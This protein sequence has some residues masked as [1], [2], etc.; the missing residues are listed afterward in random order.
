[1]VLGLAHVCFV[2]SDLNRAVEF[3]GDHLGFQVAFEF[4]RD[5]GERYGVYMKA[6]KRT[7]IEMFQ[8]VLGPRA[9]KQ[10]YGHI[11][12]EVDDVAK[13]V[14]ELRAKGLELTDAKLGMDQ[15]W[16]AW[17]A[18][19]DGNRIELHGYTPQSWQTPH[20]G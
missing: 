14:A 2:V 8:G 10:S 11:C 6:G 1:M 18:D 3:Y 12:L 15:A 4:R 17:L 13:T 5:S 20:L 9:E 19:P 16:Q 7:F